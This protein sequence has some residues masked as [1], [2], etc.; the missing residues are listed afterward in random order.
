VLEP[1]LANPDTRLMA[2]MWREGGS[3]RVVRR[4]P[5]VSAASKILPL[6]IPQDRRG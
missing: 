3:L 4:P 5:H 6:H 2:D 1:L